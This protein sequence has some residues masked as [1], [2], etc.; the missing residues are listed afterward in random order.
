MKIINKIYVKFSKF[1]CFD[2]VYVFCRSIMALIMLPCD[3]PWWPAVIKQL[4]K[5]ALARNSDDLINVMQQ[6]HDMC[7][8]DSFHFYTYLC[9]YVLLKSK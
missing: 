4:D 3:L 9:I 8:Y 6:L 1:A 7:K 2:S 5:A